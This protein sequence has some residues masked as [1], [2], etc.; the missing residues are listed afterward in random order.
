M[1]ALYACPAL[2]LVLLMGVAGGCV[3]I[4][5]TD[6]EWR[7]DE[8]R[9]SLV[10]PGHQDAEVVHWER[11]RYEI[12]RG[13]R[14][15]V[16]FFPGSVEFREQKHVRWDAWP[17][18]SWFEYV[19]Y[20]T[21][22]QS[23]FAI[24]TISSLFFVPFGVTQEAS[25][26]GL[27]G[28]HR[29]NVN[30]NTEVVV[31]KGPSAVV[32]KKVNAPEEV[33]C[34]R[35]VI[36]KTGDGADLYFDYPGFDTLLVA[37][38]KKGS[39]CVADLD[40]TMAY[41]RFTV[42]RT[43]PSVLE[44]TDVEAGG[45]VSADACIR[46]QRGVRALE[47]PYGALLTNPGYVFCDSGTSNRIDRLGRRITELVRNADGR[48]SAL[49]VWAGA[50][51]RELKCVL[52]QAFQ[53]GRARMRREEE[54][55]IAVRAEQE[56]VRAAEEERVRKIRLAEEAKRREAEQLRRRTSLKNAQVLQERKSWEALAALCRDELTKAE[57]ES[58]ALDRAESE[59]AEEGIGPWKSFL[60][61]AER[62]ITA[63]KWQK[64]KAEL[65]AE[66]SHLLERRK[67]QG[68]LDEA[69]RLGDRLAEWLKGSRSQTSLQREKS[70][71]KFLGRPVAITGKIND[72]Y[73]DQFLGTKALYVSLEAVKYDWLNTA[74]VRFSISDEWRERAL[75]WEKGSTMT[76]YGKV[77]ALG[78]F[79][80]EARVCE[81]RP[82]A[83]GVRNA[84]LE[85]ERRIQGIQLELRGGPSSNVSC[86]TT[87][88]SSM[89]SPKRDDADLVVK[90]KEETEKEEDER[91]A[92]ELGV[93]I[94]K[95]VD[96]LDR[97]GL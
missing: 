78:N 40:G 30:A 71:E 32:L 5:N 89:V 51:I 73:E 83:R 31:E 21:V 74:N 91:T 38:R 54:A 45:D 2:L 56:R 16:G 25:V 35:P 28:C 62:E 77:A 53:E 65:E 24:P 18:D 66:L 84:S 82:L 8:R 90:T 44:Y 85:M 46:Y 92:I 15:A 70:F 14:M 13:R 19:F 68:N 3:V 47:L 42:S 60:D 75:G 61:R 17:S 57:S 34:R 88:T 76:L 80:D 94:L 79:P 87:A 93:D 7:D 29:W 43:V 9:T 26:Y 52:A 10:G 37:A 22:G 11:N 33:T 1:N 23:C 49:A 6:L 39:V 97:F 72:I 12:D 48:D 50:E 86:P 59:P 4:H 55:R 63:I 69:F 20:S 36:G 27:V 64:R 95:F 58:A 67:T 96:A 81:A 41:R